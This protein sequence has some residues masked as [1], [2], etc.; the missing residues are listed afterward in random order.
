[1]PSG[2]KQQSKRGLPLRTGKKKG[3]IAAYYELRY[4]ERKLLRMYRNGSSAGEMKR[5]AYDYKAPSGAS[6]VGALI[7]IGKRFAINFGETVKI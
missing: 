5:W 3:K 6:A 4:P 7:K 1:M 2:K